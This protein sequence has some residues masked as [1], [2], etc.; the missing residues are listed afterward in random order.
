MD[1][2]KMDVKNMDVKNMDVKSMD[3]K[4]MDAQ[5]LEQPKCDDGA[6]LRSFYMYNSAYSIGIST[7]LPLR[8]VYPRSWL[9]KNG[10]SPRPGHNQ[11]LP[12]CPMCD[13]SFGATV[14]EL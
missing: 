2:D 6:S 10:A 4:S 5:K 14:A 1:L 13:R 9:A 7:P 8:T 12:R 11:T 3:V